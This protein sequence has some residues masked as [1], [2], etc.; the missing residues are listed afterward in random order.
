MIRKN[1]A[2]VQIRLSIAESGF[3]KSFLCG[4]LRSLSQW[5]R[6]PVCGRLA[7]SCELSQPLCL[8]WGDRTAIELFAQGI[9]TIAAVLIIGIKA[10]AV[11]SAYVSVARGAVNVRK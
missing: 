2:N 3:L 4:S 1:R 10:L 5:H 11:L 9:G 8:P 6:V 7:V